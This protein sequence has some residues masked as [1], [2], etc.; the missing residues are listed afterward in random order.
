MANVNELILRADEEHKKGNG[1][2]ALS[3]LKVALSIATANNDLLILTKLFCA[4]LRF[5]NAEL[6]KN[7][8]QKACITAQTSDELYECAKTAL[9]KR[10]FHNLEISKKLIRAAEAKAKDFSD[11]FLLGKRVYEEFSWVRAPKKY[12]LAGLKRFDISEEQ[13]KE[14]YAFSLHVLKDRAFA[15]EFAKICG[16][17]IEEKNLNLDEMIEALESHYSDNDDLEEMVNDLREGSSITYWAGRLASE[18]FGKNVEMSINLLNIALEKAED[19]S[20]L[21][22]IAETISDE[23][24]LGDKEWGKDVYTKALDRCETAGDYL[25]IAESVLN[26]TF[27][28]DREWARKIF[29]MAQTHSEDS[30]DF[31][32][33]AESLS[34][35]WCMNDKVWGRQIFQKALEMEDSCVGFQS[36][37]ESVCKEEYLGDISW[38]RDIYKKALEHAEDVEDLQSLAESICYV[39]Y[40]NDKSWAREIYQQAIEKAGK[41]SEVLCAIAQSILD[42]DYLDD[43]D[44]AESLAEEYGL[45]L[46]AE[47]N[48][49]DEYDNYEDSD[50]DDVEVGEGR[51]YLKTEPGGEYA[52]G[53]LSVEDV[54]ELRQLYGKDEEM[55]ESNFVEYPE[56]FNSIG[57]VYGVITSLSAEGDMINTNEY[58]VSYIEEK[59]MELPRDGDGEILDGFYLM[60]SAPT[61]ISLDVDLGDSSGHLELGY[62]NLDLADFE[63]SYGEIEFSILNNVVFNGNEIDLSECYVD[64]GYDKNIT[65]VQVKDGEWAKV[66]EMMGED[67]VW[68]EFLD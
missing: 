42:Q 9:D 46:E 36:L 27:Q 26:D 11:L 45:K 28:G 19:S 7:L 44:W 25:S 48:E 29:Q 55:L 63:D 23:Q 41:D 18:E 14:C 12:F 56:E 30:S 54:N 66:F 8:F 38:A 16:L 62:V 34:T 43:R 10:Y 6:A 5:K 40:L 3:L 35:E 58:D 2:N 68:Q 32:N 64:Q 21:K 53:R 22:D 37:A 50:E 52:C 60:Y 33:L 24:Y 20:D 31:R 47:D 17:E 51:L 49:E 61:K 65:I 59:V 57:H 67:I 1:K 4:D 39:D 13:K 15:K